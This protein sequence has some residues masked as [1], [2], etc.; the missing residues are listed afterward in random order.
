MAGYFKRIGQ[1]IKSLGGHK[2]TAE[3]A[4]EAPSHPVSETETT[5]LPPT[6]NNTETATSPLPD[7]NLGT[8]DAAV[9]LLFP[10]NDRQDLWR[11]AFLKLDDAE[12]AVLDFTP[13]PYDDGNADENKDGGSAKKADMASAIQE[14]LGT[15][16]ALKEKDDEKQYATVS[17]RRIPPRY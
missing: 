2:G 1:K 5:P 10:S 7:E 15:A 17:A 12:R 11:E 8:K 4:S 13:A 9:P 14:I 6:E 16:N 3:S